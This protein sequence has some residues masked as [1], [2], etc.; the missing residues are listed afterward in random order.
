MRERPP[1]GPIRPCPLR[2][3]SLVRVVSPAYP[4][5]ALVSHRRPRAERALRGLG[6]E[7]DYGASAFARLG[8]LAGTAE[9]RAADLNQAF[10]DPGVG[11]IICALG[12]GSSMELAPLLD[13]ELI[14]ANPKPFI[15]HSDNSMIMMPLLTDAG[16]VTFHG[17]SLVNQLGEFPEPFPETLDGLVRA[18]CGAEP[19]EFRPAERRTDVLPPWWNEPDDSVSRPRNLAGGW[20][21][22]KPGRAS[23]PLLGGQIN[24]L[25]AMLHSRWAPSFEGAILFWDAMM[26]QTPLVDAALG[27]LSARGVL[28]GC[29]GMVVGHPARLRQTPQTAPFEDVVAKWA[30]EVDGPVLLNADCGHTDPCWTLPYGGVAH[31]DSV[32]DRFWAEPGTSAP[33][34]GPAERAV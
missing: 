5:L 30:E 12:G 18:V 25:L 17:P 15:G 7:V 4:A 33:G 2:P 6:F 10:A 27:R 3:G 26:W 1:D 29:A 23:G 21:W 20:R 19:L 9:Q 28:A 24:S 32:A 8:H 13:Y 31:L 22:L 14:R 11:A 16:L 34:A